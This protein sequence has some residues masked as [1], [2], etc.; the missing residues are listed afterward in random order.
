MKVI[1]RRSSIFHSAI[2]VATCM[3]KFTKGMKAE[4]V[5]QE[6][7][8]QRNL[9]ERGQ[10]NDEA[11][12]LLNKQGLA[13]GMDAGALTVATEVLCY[14]NN[15]CIDT[16]FCCSTYSCVHPSKCLHG[17]KVKEDYC[18]YNF[19]CYSR[20]CFENL[21]SHFLNCHETCTKNSDCQST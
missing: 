21:C 8:T 10:H 17:E 1:L 15:D 3:L 19:E 12:I 4:N 5:F 9:I 7:I 6:F 18:D 14:K 16:T 2:L 11:T 20:C 13:G